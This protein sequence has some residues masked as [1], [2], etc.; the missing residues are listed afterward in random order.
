MESERDKK[1]RTMKKTSTKS[2]SHLEKRFES[3]WELISQIP[4]KRQIKG[5]IPGRRY[6]YDFQLTGTNILIEIQGGIWARGYSGHTSGAGI[7]RDTDKVN[8]AQLN[9][10]YI[11][12]LTEEKLNVKYLEQIQQFASKQLPDS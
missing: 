6:V 1:L 3:V 4:L 2:D 9:G 10:Y 5:I 11:F 7:K 12:Q 8:Q